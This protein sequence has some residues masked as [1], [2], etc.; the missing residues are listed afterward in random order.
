MQSTVNKYVR[1][2]VAKTQAGS[3]VLTQRAMA[4]YGNKLIQA[5]R[6]TALSC[7]LPA[8]VADHF[9]SLKRGKTIVLPDGSYVMEISFTDDLTRPSLQPAGYEGVNNIIAIFNNGYPDDS[10]RASA[11]A[12]ISGWWHGQYTHALGMR[13]GLHFMQDAVND[14]NQTYGSKFGIY[15]TVGE[16]YNE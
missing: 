11:I 16:I 14:F 13:Q 2:G 10:S 6:D 7:N 8:S 12:S 5:I 15:A 1:T 3:R 9:S 4:D